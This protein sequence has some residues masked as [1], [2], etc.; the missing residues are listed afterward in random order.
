[1]KFI[2]EIEN[3]INKFDNKGLETYVAVDGMLGKIP[4]CESFN[5]YMN[6]YY[7]MLMHKYDHVFVDK[8]KTA[9]GKEYSLIRTSLLKHATKETDNYVLIRFIGNVLDD[10][11]LIYDSLATNENVANEIKNFLIN[12][13]YV[14]SEIEFLSKEGEVIQNTNVAQLEN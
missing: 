9:L 13:G 2:A 6:Y 11:M 1:M 3:K 5:E 8:A 7:P 12:Q 14:V 10:E 4:V